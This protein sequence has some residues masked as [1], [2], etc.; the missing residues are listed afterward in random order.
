M[1]ATNG[2]GVILENRYYGQS[3]PFNTSTTDN[4]GY[5]TT[6]Q[7]LLCSIGLGCCD[8]TTLA[9]A[10]NAYFAQ[11][12]VFPGVAGNLTAPGTPWILYGGSLAGAETA[13]SVKTYGNI[14]FGGIASSAPIK[15]VLP[16]PEW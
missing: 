12:A 11:N 16:Y 15:V 5:L 6:E 8:L 3:Y 7:S 4:L 13:F 2:L 10:D 14:L 9:I 1:Q